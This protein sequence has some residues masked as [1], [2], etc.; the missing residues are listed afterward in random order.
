MEHYQ[1]CI[2]MGDISFDPQQKLIM[3]EL[4]RVYNDLLT[5]FDDMPEEKSS[6][7]KFISRTFSPS[8]ESLK[9]QPLVQ[10]LYIWGGVGYGKTHMVDFF[11]KFLPIENK[12]RLHFHRF[13]QIVH[14][15]LKQ[16]THIE[17]PLKAVAK[18]LSKKT[19][20]LCLDEMHINDITD[21]MILAQLF[22]HL[23]DYGVTLVTTSNVPP[24]GLYKD[25]LQRSRFLPTIALFEEKTKVVNM[26]SG[27]DYRLRLLEQADVYQ[28]INNSLT[29]EVADKK[30][31]D[32]F[33]SLTAINRHNK[34]DYVLIND[35][36][37]PVIKWADGI[38]WFN[39]ETLCETSRSTDDY[40]Q[41][42]R[43]FHTIMISDIPIMSSMQNDAA[44]R[45]VNMIDE[46]Y[47]RHV[48]VIV[49]AEALPTELY[50]G[51]RL[52]FE[53][54]RTASRLIEMQSKD[55]LAKK[56]GVN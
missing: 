3:L 7:N 12:M 2:E 27:I 33:V 34:R 40:I 50:I 25:G 51:T 36:K 48:N 30:M 6:F 43:F 38:T 47:D 41:L 37:I 4:Q 29:K 9:V 53:F 17:N 15:D 54:E 18:S 45:F 21:A 10:G 22:T 1:N 56:R 32:Y 23:F 31:E 52:A 8:K 24:S 28:L 20:L 16:H 46:F 11:F 13:M 42:G 44:R 35:R 49:T 19:R 14:E 5:S 55:Y 26:D 39:F